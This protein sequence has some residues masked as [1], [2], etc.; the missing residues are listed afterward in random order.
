MRRLA[1]A[2]ALVLAGCGATTRQACYA[3]AETD[4][5][6]VAYEVCQAQGYAWPTCP[7]RPALLEKLRA[8][9]AACP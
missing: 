5:V 8:R 1:A 7:A 6:A 4:F 3:S 2:M 9:E